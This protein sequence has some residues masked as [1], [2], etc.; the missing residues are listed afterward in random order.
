MLVV[1]EGESVGAMVRIE[2]AGPVLIPQMDGLLVND[3][4]TRDHHLLENGDL[5]SFGERVLRV[6][7]S[8]EAKAATGG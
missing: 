8:A 3:E 6:E 5:I 7:A 2:D 1:N 4:A